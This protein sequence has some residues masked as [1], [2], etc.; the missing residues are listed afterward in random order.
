MAQTFH[1]FHYLPT[2]LKLHVLRQRLVLNRPI[3]ATTHASHSARCLL[4]LAL[5]CKDFKDL[6]YE[7]Y[8]KENTF[9]ASRAVSRTLKQCLWSY[10][11]P[12]IGAWIRKLEVHIQVWPFTSSV[13]ENWISRDGINGWRY[14]LVKN[15]LGSYESDSTVWQRHFP[16]LA[17][18]KVVL[19]FNATELAQIM[20]Q[21][22][23]SHKD[24]EVLTNY[25]IGLEARHVEVVVKGIDFCLDAVIKG[26]HL[27]PSGDCC[28]AIIQSTIKNQI[29][30]NN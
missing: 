1:D 19:E 13:G 10:P 15:S 24:M 7:I 26:A 14:L 2:E 18:L 6:A 29:S 22:G 3:T 4:P 28:K 20:L 12:A 23:W 30:I 25:T 17:T 8:Y 27:R 5:T 16:A 9:V 21:Q 11:N